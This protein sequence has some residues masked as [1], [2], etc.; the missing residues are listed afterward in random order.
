MMCSVQ[1][2]H[3]EYVLSVGTL[4]LRLSSHVDKIKIETN[5]IPLFITLRT[6]TRL[7][8]YFILWESATF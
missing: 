6:I 5:M 7:S 8:S 4:V 2:M 1:I 3:I